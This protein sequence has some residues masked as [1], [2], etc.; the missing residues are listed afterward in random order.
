MGSI[1][2]WQNLTVAVVGNNCVFC[3]SGI[4]KYLIWEGGDGGGEARQGVGEISVYLQILLFDLSDA[5]DV[6]HMK[7]ITD[8]QEDE[9]PSEMFIFRNGCLV[10]WNVAESTVS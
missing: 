10:F 6:L 7:V 1:F 9:E 3:C 2:L 5:H 8:S 4:T